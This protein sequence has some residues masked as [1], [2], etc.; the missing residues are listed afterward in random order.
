VSWE[1]CSTQPFLEDSGVNNSNPTTKRGKRHQDSRST[2]RSPTT[3]K[4]NNHR[5]ERLLIE[6]EE[7]RNDLLK[8]SGDKRG[9]ARGEGN[10]TEKRQDRFKQIE[11]EASEGDG[12]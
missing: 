5:I 8:L 6:R 11:Q 9:K 10:K 7:A 4:N 3:Q 12:K 1:D 2:R